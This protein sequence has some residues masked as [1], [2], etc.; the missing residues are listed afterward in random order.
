MRSQGRVKGNL[1]VGV[2]KRVYVWVCVWVCNHIACMRICVS[3]KT[4]LLDLFRLS[5][6]MLGIRAVECLRCSRLQYCLVV[7]VVVVVVV[8]VDT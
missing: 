3:S 6:H 4:A 2:H 1:F 7:V 8:A 5:N